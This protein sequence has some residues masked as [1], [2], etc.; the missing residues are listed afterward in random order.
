MDGKLDTE[1]PFVQPYGTSGELLS[2]SRC[3][4]RVALT[5]APHPTS[6]ASLSPC[7]RRSLSPAAPPSDHRLMAP[8]TVPYAR[9]VRGQPPLDIRG[10][11]SETHTGTL[12]CPPPFAVLTPACTHACAPPERLLL[13]PR[14]GSSARAT[15]SQRG[16]PRKA[17]AGTRRPLNR[18]QPPVHAYVALSPSLALPVG[19]PARCSVPTHQAAR[20]RGRVHHSLRR[21]TRPRACLTPRAWRWRPCARGPPPRG[22]APAPSAS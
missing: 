9:A 3:S 13:A 21:G 1:L 22:A 17:P 7:P 5:L 12:D 8:L 4:R 2:R 18:S 11:H 19:A 14:F 6:V 20:E 15:A 16:I 10:T